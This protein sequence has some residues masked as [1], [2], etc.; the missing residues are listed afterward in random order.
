MS[1]KTTK[2]L[3]TN[4]GKNERVAYGPAVWYTEDD[5]YLFTYGHELQLPEARLQNWYPA[6][7]T[8]PKDTNTRFQTM[9]HYIMYSKAMCF[10][11]EETAKKI[12]VAATPKEA[13]ALGR[14][15]KNFDGKKWREIVPEVAETGNWLK[16]SQ[17]AECRDALLATGNRILAESNPEDRNWGIGFRGDEAAGRE[18]EWGTNLLG[19]AQMK[20]R[21]RLTKGETL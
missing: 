18:S 17:V 21:D 10:N 19:N 1:I 12:L 2:P 11:D 9:E 4:D 20:V 15:V 3:T 13:Q 7:F 14:Q 6:S 8:D 16:F 5:K